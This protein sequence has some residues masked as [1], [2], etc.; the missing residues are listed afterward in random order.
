MK[1]NLVKIKFFFPKIFPEVKNKREFVELLIEAMR[2][3][4]S[5]KYAGYLKEKNLYKDLMRHI[6]NGDISQYKPLSTK[7]K[8]VI[9]KTILTTVQKCNKKLPIPIKN[10]VFVFPWFPVKNDKAFKGSF[11]FAAYSCVLHIFISPQIF[12]QKSLADSITHELNH[13]ISFYY[14]P[15]RYGK[16]S[17]LDY[18]INEGLAENFREEALNKKS[19]QW[20][21]ALTK[22]EAFEALELIHPL[23]HSKDSNVHQKIL[24]GNTKY[25]RW[26]GYSIGY[27]IVKEFRNKHKKLTWEKIMKT[28]PEDILKT[29][30]KKRA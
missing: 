1:S 25:K 20:A 28:K 30:I 14:H 29:I 2:K 27:W 15:D 24:F 21:I 18:I 8:Q 17:L 9:E 23:L 12:T 5:I 7:Q 4:G 11:G 26:T 16:W 19:A 6:G 13:T 10:F 22:K 3:N